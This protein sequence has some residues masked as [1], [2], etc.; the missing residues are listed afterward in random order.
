MAVAAETSETLGDYCKRLERVYTDQRAA[1]GLPVYVRI[2][3]VRFSRFTKGMTRPFHEPL[4]RAMIETT[5]RIMEKYPAI[6]GYTQS[7]EI[8]LVFH[9][10]EHEIH[11]GGKFQKLVS[12]LASC[13]TAA[14][15]AAATDQGMTPYL[16]R[17]FPEFDARAFPVATLDEAR[18]M[19][20]WREIDARKNAITMVARC[21]YSHR[22][23]QGKHS[24]DMLEMLSAKSIAFDDYPEFFRRGT[25]VR[26]V[27]ELRDLTAEELARIPPQHRPE[28][29]VLRHR[30]VESHACPDFDEPVAAN[31]SPPDPQT[32]GP[33]SHE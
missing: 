27:T 4:S 18:E 32:V 22:D 9:H 14:F 33:A 6:I 15:H 10:A 23:I 30:M 2:D 28:G 29:P 19:L 3:G 5:K 26:R 7:D 31:V 25:F 21:V 13:A 16:E 24:D 11:H 20:R 17:Q 1:I 8:S 12:R